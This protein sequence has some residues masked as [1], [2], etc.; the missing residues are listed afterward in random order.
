MARNGKCPE[1]GRDLKM[2]WFDIHSYRHK[3]L[4]C[5]WCD[6]T[7]GGSYQKKNSDLISNRIK[8][9]KDLRI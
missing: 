9:L 3:I 1:C 5:I 4:K 2:E 8:E 7:C 6:F